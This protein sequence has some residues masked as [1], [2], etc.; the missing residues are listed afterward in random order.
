ML[1][2]AKTIIIIAGALVLVLTLKEK[3][4]G[5]FSQSVG[6]TL[7]ADKGLLSAYHQETL[8]PPEEG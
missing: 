4:E 7:W 6:M 3:A 2:F 8:S 1:E 5:I